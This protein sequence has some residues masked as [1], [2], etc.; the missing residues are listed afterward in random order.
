MKIGII[1]SKK[2]ETVTMLYKE[3]IKQG[4]TV[5]IL[6]INK[7]SILLNNNKENLIYYNHKLLSD[8]DAFITR[9]PSEKSDIGLSI[10]R[11][12]E[13]KGIICFNSWISISRANNKFRT[14]QILSSKNFNMP[15]TF[16]TNNSDFSKKMLEQ[17]GMPVIIKFFNG[18]QG[19]GVMKVDTIESA[20]SVLE[21]IKILDSNVLVQECINES[22]GRD[23]RVLVVGGKVVASMERFSNGDDFRANLSQGGQ[24]R[25]IDLTKEEKEM[26]IKATKALSLDICGVDIIRT[27]RG[28]MI[29]ELN[30]SPGLVGIESSTG[31]SVKTKIFQEIVKAVNKKRNVLY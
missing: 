22:R 28:S 5:K 1:C 24:A 23:I 14:Q 10:I 2:S 16:I 3:G 7:F 19:V 4:H 26:A 21:S 9:I 13:L 20:L 18:L 29:L 25:K 17:L 12:I 15:K 27:N 8:Y 6:Y 11:Q 31:I 30:A